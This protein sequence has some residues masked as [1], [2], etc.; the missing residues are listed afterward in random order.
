MRAIEQLSTILAAVLKPIAAG[1]TAPAGWDDW[2]P[3]AT[4]CRN[5]ANSA[6]RSFRTP[7]RW[8]TGAEA[9]Y[10]GYEWPGSGRRP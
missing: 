8:L 1:H 4:R 9:S 7:I 10:T 5:S 6:A 3:F 2:D